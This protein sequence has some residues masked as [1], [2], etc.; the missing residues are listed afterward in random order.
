[1]KVEIR[2]TARSGYSASG[3][4]HEGS[5][6]PLLPCPFCGPAHLDMVELVNTHTPCY[7]VACG[8]CDADGPSS[9][10]WNGRKVRSLKACVTLHRDA[11]VQ[12]VSLWNTRPV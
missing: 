1:M 2:G 10:V 5:D 4:Y 12:A 11:M 6:P 3:Q 7:W 8:N 9:T